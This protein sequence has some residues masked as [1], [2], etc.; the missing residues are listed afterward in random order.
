MKPAQLKM[1]QALSE[2]AIPLLGYFWWNWDLYFIL[3]FY[4]L[5]LLVSSGFSFVRER[6]ILQY[7]Q[8]PFSFPTQQLLLTTCLLGLIF[9]IALQAFFQLIPAFNPLA[10]TW[11]FLAY[12][13]LGIPQGIVLI[14]LVIYAGYAQYRMH[15]LMPGKFSTQTIREVRKTHFKTLLLALAAAALWLGSTYF[16][17]GP[18]LLYVLVLIAGATAYRTLVLR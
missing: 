6:K 13:E 10:E 18:E 7:R 9:F 5:D 2:L 15:F 3:L 12:E 1:V 14:P 4:V 8:Q 17:A 11:K 16:F